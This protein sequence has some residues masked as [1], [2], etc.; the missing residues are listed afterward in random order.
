MTRIIYENVPVLFE[1]NGDCSAITLHFPDE[2][3]GKVK[4]L[5]EKLKNQGFNIATSFV[6]DNA[7]RIV[8]PSKGAYDER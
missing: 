2:F 1:T 7:I 5:R 4:E 8:T 6:A 3:A